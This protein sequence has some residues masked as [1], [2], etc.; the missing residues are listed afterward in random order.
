[1]EK[2]V[3]IFVT[4]YNIAKYLDRFFDCLKKQSF[5][6]YEVLIIEDGST[7]DSLAICRKYAAEDDRIR[8]LHVSHVG[9]SAARNLAL[10]N[11]HTEFATSLDGDDYF[12]K[13]YLSHL[14]DAQK[15]YDADLVISNV[16]YNR[17]DG[18]E[19]RRFDPREEALYTK[20]QFPDIL[21]DLLWEGRLNYL[22]GKLYRT[23]ELRGIRVDADVKQGSDTMI[24]SIYVVRINSIAIIE[25]YDYHYVNYTSRSVT[26]YKGKGL[27]ERW[28]RIDR[29]V[30]YI[31]RMNKLLNE[32][33][34]NAINLRIL[35]YGKSALTNIAKSNIS[36]KEKY[37]LASDV[38]N[39][40]KYMRAYTRMDETGSLGKA[41]FA[42]EPGTEKEYIDKVYSGFKQAERDRRR[43]ELRKHCP[44]FLFDMYHRSKILLGLIPPDKTE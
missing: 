41:P 25:D 7:D 10:Q 2:K 33:M 13:D 17:E 12:G 26:S 43:R 9:I 38:I 39:G 28:Y 6:D 19:I 22:Y 27:F 11:I 14:V 18:S 31:M 5:K 42:I 21:P 36:L 37:R 44:D 30:Y 23:E 24:N 1:M 4:V 29:F 34:E 3:T 8:V 15:K 32:K 16:I 40:K 20:E 35:I